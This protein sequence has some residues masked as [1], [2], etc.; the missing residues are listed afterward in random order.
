[1]GFGFSHGRPRIGP[2]P[3]PRLRIGY[4]FGD[5]EG[6][7]L[8]IGGDWLNELSEKLLAGP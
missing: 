5:L 7:R 6:F 8:R 1:M 4:R 2:F 3:L